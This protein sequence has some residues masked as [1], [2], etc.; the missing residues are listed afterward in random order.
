MEETCLGRARARHENLEFAS[1]DEDPSETPNRRKVT[2][3]FGSRRKVAVEHV[4]PLGVG[5]TV[6]QPHWL[7]RHFPA[8][9]GTTCIGIKL[10]L[11]RAGSDGDD[12]SMSDSDDIRRFLRTEFDWAPRITGVPGRCAC[13]RGSTK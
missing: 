9:T 2:A 13:Q 3:D 12:R 6:E 7:A 10:I 1:P 5:K 11:G 8:P 4:V